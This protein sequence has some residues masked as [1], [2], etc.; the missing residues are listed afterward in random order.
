MKAVTDLD[1]Y[2]LAEQLSDMLWHDFDE[3]P[4][5]VKRTI[6]YQVSA[7][8]DSIAANI[9]ERYGRVTRADRK[10]FYVYARDS[11]EETKSW[12]RKLIRRGISNDPACIE[13]YKL[14][15]DQLGCRLNVFVKTT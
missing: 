14:I 8:V 10:H 6:G 12:L 15:V 4:D 1:V 13:R 9:A 11:L 7:A 2:R 3:W 5:K